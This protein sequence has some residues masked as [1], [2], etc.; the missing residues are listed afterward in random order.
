MARMREVT[1]RVTRKLGKCGSVGFFLNYL[2]LPDGLSR[3]PRIATVSLMGCF[4]RKEKV[5]IS[6]TA[7]EY[8]EL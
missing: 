4:Q 5:N 8:L 7:Y 3:F 6:A 1:V 2:V